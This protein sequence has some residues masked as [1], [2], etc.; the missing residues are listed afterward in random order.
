MSLAEEARPGRAPGAGSRGQ[1]G[2]LKPF[3]DLIPKEAYDN[4]TWRGMF[5]VGRDAAF[6]L[7]ALAGIV[8]VD[9]WLL[10]PVFWLLAG[11]SAF[12]LFLV[13]HDTVHGALFRSKRLNNV[14]GHI[15]LLPSLTPFSPWDLGHN[16][17]HHV[18]TV[19]RSRDPVWE[20]LTPQQ[21]DALPRWR[22]AQ[23]KV[24]WSW[25]GPGLY[26]LRVP[27]SK[28][29]LTDPG[30]KRAKVQHRDRAFTIVWAVAVAGGVVA[31]GLARSDSALA[32]AWL[33]FQVV[34][35]PFVIC[36]TILGWVVKVQHV[37]PDRQW[38]GDET[39]NKVRAQV[40]GTTVVRMPRGLDVFFHWIMIHVP[41][42]VDMRVPMY[43]L[44]LAADALIEGRPDLVRE[45]RFTART[46]FDI[47]RDCKLFDDDTQ[48]WLTYAEGA[49]LLDARAAETT[50]VAPAA[51]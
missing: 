37:A 42:H 3:L 45:E 16:R 44:P 41:H 15:T 8:I 20:P 38:H 7:A 17:A 47:T 32:A 6:Y 19:R 1:A 35:V 46:W 29:F 51:T 28:L 30:P 13:G 9:N 50:P 33:A 23:H 40:E 34:I 21:Y 39:W 36:S 31:L 11:L 22:R 48:T 27:W 25:M 26:Y 43:R 10:R 14:V 5:Y 18:H 2:S 24:E 12:A 49:A 4:P